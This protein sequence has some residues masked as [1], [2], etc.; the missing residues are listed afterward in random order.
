[1][2]HK[3]RDKRK[4]YNRNGVCVPITIQ[5]NGQNR[6]LDNHK[7]ISD[8]LR[9]LGIPSRRVI[10]ERNREIVDKSSIDQV[11]L[12]DGDKVEIIRIVGGG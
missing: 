12:E 7:S 5:V 1:L 8:L 9:M 6:S 3:A 11:I 4:R 2:G 10:V